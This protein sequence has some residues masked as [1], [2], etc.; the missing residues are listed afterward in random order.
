MMGTDRP[1]VSALHHLKDGSDVGIVTYS[2]VSPDPCM[3]LLISHARA[4]TPMSIGQTQTCQASR[5]YLIAISVGFCR[6]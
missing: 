5:D 1:A 4:P 6:A 2:G 3:R